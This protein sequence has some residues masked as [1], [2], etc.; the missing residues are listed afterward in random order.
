M[1][2]Y[3]AHRRDGSWRA[4]LEHLVSYVCV[5]VHACGVVIVV[6]RWYRMREEACQYEGNKT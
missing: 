2:S 5:H 4:D 1:S 3:T 6:V